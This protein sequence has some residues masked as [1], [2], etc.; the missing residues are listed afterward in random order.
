[1]RSLMRGALIGIAASAFLL[2]G[3]GE[4]A[5]LPEQASVGPNP[6]IPAPRQSWVPTVNI[7][8]AAAWPQNERPIPAPGLAVKAFATGLDHPRWLHV[9]PN[10]D[11][12]VA[13]TNAPERP[14]DGKGIKGWFFKMFQKRAGAAVPSANRITLLR[15]A[16]G[17]GVAETRTVLLQ[18]LNSPFGMA[19]AGRDLYVA[20]TDA[21]M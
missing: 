13:E 12:L 5:E 8:D 11:V 19:L 15:D 9:L 6:Q 14:E 20:N 21:V 1:M 10:G 3:C 7:A 2:A 18:N 4:K 17:D 16:D